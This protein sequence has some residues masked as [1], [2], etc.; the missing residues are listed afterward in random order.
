MIKKLVR[1]VPVALG[2]LFLVLFIFLSTANGQGKVK[3]QKGSSSRASSELG[4][5]GTQFTINGKPTFLYGISYYGALGAP[6]DFIIRDLAD[7]KAYGFNWIRVW[8]IWNTFGNDVAAVDGNGNPRE[9][10]YSKLKWLVA[11]CDSR[12]I[13]VDVTLY[14]GKEGTVPILQTLDSHRRAVE[15]IINLL[16][17][18]KNWYMD[19]AN[20]FDVHDARFV[21]LEDL[22]QLCETA[23]KMNP[24]LLVTAS[25]GLKNP[26]FLCKYLNTVNVDFI[27]PHGRRFEGSP[28]QT[29]AKTKEYFSWMKGTGG[30]T[31]PIHFQEPFRHG[32]N[33]WQPKAGDFVNDVLNSKAGGAAG[34]CF[35]NGSQ[36]E[37]A[38]K[39]PRRSFDM[40]EKRL[41][42]QLDNVELEAIGTISKVLKK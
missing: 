6:E 28:E 19:L 8:A 41:F 20:E 39:N 36:K 34:W 31:V 26:D 17:P 13:I 30:R 5:K 23:K 2:T 42:D 12:G 27:C 21:S 4:I 25:G 15:A 7:I 11:E 38:E 16:K 9:P 33:K 40:R 14:R 29:E 24:E 37:Q 1:L 35:H 3:K 10:F 22:K 18:Y 32:Y